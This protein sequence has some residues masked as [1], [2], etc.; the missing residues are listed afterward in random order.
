[1]RRFESAVWATDF[2][3][4]RAFP[5]LTGYAR[6]GFILYKLYYA[7]ADIL[8]VLEELQRHPI[9]WQCAMHNNHVHRVLNNW[10]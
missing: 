2:P 4:K 9:I 8:Q 5:Y 6:A 1:M 3:P 7:I 10:T